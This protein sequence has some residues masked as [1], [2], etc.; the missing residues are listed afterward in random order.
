MSKLNT[1]DNLVDLEKLNQA[2]ENE[3]VE[4]ETVEEEAE[5]SK[6][7]E[8]GTDENGAENE[9]GESAETTE[10]ETF[11]VAEFKRM[12][13]MFGAEIAAEIVSSG[14]DEADGWKMRAEKA[15]KEN[16]ELQKR[17]EAVESNQSKGGTPAKA[18][19]ETGKKKSIWS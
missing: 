10:A 15:E 14:G 9:S 5:T 18:S 1:N 6:N 7:D 4:T 17:V 19:A 13:E 2:N 16:V 11:D 8:T 3:D 12:K